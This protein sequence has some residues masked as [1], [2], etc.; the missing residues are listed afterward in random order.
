[1]IYLDSSALVKLV[2]SEAE[3][4]ALGRW[5]GLNPDPV[6]SSALARTEVVRAVMN[7]GEP[8]RDRARSVLSAIDVVPITNDLLDEAATLTNVLRTL[9]AIHLATACLLRADLHAFVA[10]DKRLLAAADE[11]GLVAVAPG[12][13]G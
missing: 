12:A 8:L 5:L 13:D 4:A 10:Y 9:D 11:V 1:M 2:R 3:S 6:V 7:G